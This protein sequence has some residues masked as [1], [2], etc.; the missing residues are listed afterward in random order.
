MVDQ[1]DLNFQK[2]TELYEKLFNK[3]FEEAHNASADVAATARSF[4]ELL[5]IG[6]I[7]NLDTDL[8]NKF[9]QKNTSTINEYPTINNIIYQENTSIPNEEESK[10]NFL[11]MNFLLWKKIV[12]PLIFFHM[13]YSLFYFAVNSF[14]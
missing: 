5:R 4:F 8:I 10:N 14:Y 13:P 1:V 3:I 9:Q 6:L 12:L 7:E 11:K 2:L